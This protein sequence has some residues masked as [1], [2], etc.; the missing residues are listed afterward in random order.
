LL[1]RYA[2][3]DI[4]VEDPPLEDVIAD[5]FTRVDEPS[6]PTLGQVPELLNE[7]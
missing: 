4:S 1:S 5:M 2:I 6:E 7:E 3:V